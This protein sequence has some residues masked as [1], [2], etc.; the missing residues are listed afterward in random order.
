MRYLLEIAYDGTAFHG[1]QVQGELHTVQF[2]LNKALSTLLRQPIETFGASRTDEGVHALGNAYHFDWEDGIHPQLIYKLN[3]L[4][5]AQMAVKR[6]MQA[7]KPDFNARFDASSRSYR[8]KIYR[9]KDPFKQSRALFFP[10]PL[11]L[12]KLNATAAVIK[13]Y[14]DFESFCKRNSQTFTH[15]CTIFRSY[16]EDHGDELHYIVEANRFLRG[17]VRALVGTQ[18]K[19]MK[20]EDPVAA[21]R[22]IIEAKNC[23]L[24]DF[25]VTG[26]G[27]YLEAVNFPEGFLEEI[28]QER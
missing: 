27:L 2:A 23:T 8:Y 15:N 14:I 6:L 7:V 20:Q 22:K 24:A 25:S 19:V 1:S 12:D 26:N 16:W 21:L 11:Q 18:L 4:L 3:A 28:V 13:E 17:M 5:P 9:K 10:Y